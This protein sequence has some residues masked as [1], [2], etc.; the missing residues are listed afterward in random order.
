M[1]YHMDDGQREKFMRLKNPEGLPDA[2]AKDLPQDLKNWLRDVYGPAFV[3]QV[4][5]TIPPPKDEENWRHNLSTKEQDKLWYW[6]NGSVSNLSSR[7]PK[8]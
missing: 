4:I 7:V 3:A 8:C 2:L 5:T 6:F 1:I